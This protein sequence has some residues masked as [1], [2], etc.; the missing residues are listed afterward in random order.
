[1]FV[2]VVV[3]PFE[4]FGYLVGVDLERDWC[5]CVVAVGWLCCG[6]SWW[7]WWALFWDAVAV[8]VV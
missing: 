6:R 1:M 2:G 3:E 8:V 7:W 5:L 4:A